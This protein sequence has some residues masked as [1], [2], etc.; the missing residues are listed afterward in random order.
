MR[1][2]FLKIFSKTAIGHQHFE[3]LE[4]SFGDLT[5]NNKTL[6]DDPTILGAREFE[7]RYGLERC[8]RSSITS[9]GPVVLKDG[10]IK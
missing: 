2:I 4:N 9:R 10:E 1:N 6:S 3:H 5:K 8:R 7:N